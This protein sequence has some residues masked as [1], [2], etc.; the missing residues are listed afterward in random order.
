MRDTRKQARRWLVRLVMEEGV[1]GLWHVSTQSEILCMMGL[2]TWRAGRG[3]GS[4]RGLL[5]CGWRAVHAWRGMGWA[6]IDIEDW[7][8]VGRVW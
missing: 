7:E 5:G 3:W 8:C 1:C 2:E 6:K 4:R